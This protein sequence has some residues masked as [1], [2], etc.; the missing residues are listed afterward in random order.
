MK[1]I[2]LELL[3]SEFKGPKEIEVWLKRWKQQMADAVF[4][5]LIRDYHENVQVEKI[6]N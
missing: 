5:D 4:Y 1:C 6:N 2:S 3:A